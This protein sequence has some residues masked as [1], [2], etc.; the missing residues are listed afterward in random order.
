MLVLGATALGT[1]PCHLET[2]G[3]VTQASQ[4]RKRLTGSQAPFGDRLSQ[5]IGRFDVSN[6]R[7][8]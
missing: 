8:C 7:H 4:P 3:Q 2:S 6:V 1:L 5:G